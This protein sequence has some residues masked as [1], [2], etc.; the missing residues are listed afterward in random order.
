MSPFGES[1][2]GAPM[3][4]ALLTGVIILLGCFHLDEGGMLRIARKIAHVS[5][6]V[7]HT[8]GTSGEEIRRQFD[9][10]VKDLNLRN[11]I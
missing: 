3:M 10:V 9:V 5:H 7:G 4:G 2:D 1:I 8:R 11:E 6:Q